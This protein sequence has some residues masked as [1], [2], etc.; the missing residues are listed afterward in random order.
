MQEMHAGS[1]RDR[2][3]RNCRSLGAH[4]PS[5]SPRPRASLLGAGGASPAHSRASWRDRLW[6]KVS[7]SATTLGLAC[8]LGPRLL[9]SA[10]GSA[11]GSPARHTEGHEVGQR[12]LP[13]EV[14]GEFT[15]GEDGPL[16]DGDKDRS[17]DEGR[18]R[19][20]PQ[21]RS[22][23]GRAAE[24]VA[25]TAEVVGAAAGEAAAAAR[26][27][28]VRASRAHGCPRLRS[29]AHWAWARAKSAI[30]CGPATASPRSNA[31]GSLQR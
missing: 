14:S 27:P 29:R 6:C 31:A 2:L 7:V 18:A 16:V 19:R 11:E 24:A 10:A 4:F 12:N 26:A 25:S 15:G 5:S 17:H 28:H 22:V 1:S 30:A 13:E 23:A 20:T 9:L 21:E 8:R 3:P